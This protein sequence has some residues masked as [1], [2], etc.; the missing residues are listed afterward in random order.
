MEVRRGGGVWGCLAVGARRLFPGGLL[1]WVG[2][3]VIG[4]LSF[5]IV[6]DKT[7]DLV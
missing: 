4:E 1:S 7:A 2:G 5:F 6:S 3:G